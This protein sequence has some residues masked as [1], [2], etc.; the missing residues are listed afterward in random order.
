[1]PVMLSEPQTRQAVT[2]PEAAA[3]L[4]ISTT[5]AW[6]LVYAGSIRA[7]RLGRAVRVPLEE[8]NRILRGED[9]HAE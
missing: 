9:T 7:V 1:M 6:K 2:V 3:R 4:G 8:I 5:T